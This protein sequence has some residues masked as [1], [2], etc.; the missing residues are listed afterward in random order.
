[1]VISLCQPHHPLRRWP[2]DPRARSMPCGH[3][4]R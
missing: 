2:T 1:L 3:A 4:R